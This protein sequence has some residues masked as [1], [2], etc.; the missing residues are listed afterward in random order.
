[1]LPVIVRQLV[2]EALRAMAALASGPAA[3]AARRMFCEALAAAHVVPL[4]LTAATAPG[5]DTTTA[6]Q[7]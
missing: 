3:G 7:V 4:L 5:S 6:A 2:E 1:M